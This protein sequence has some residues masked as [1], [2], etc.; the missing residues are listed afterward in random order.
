MGCFSVAMMSELC[1]LG[2]GLMISFV[3]QWRVNGDDDN[4]GE[5]Y[6]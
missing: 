1:S 2:S 4:K 5:E 3:C 6:I